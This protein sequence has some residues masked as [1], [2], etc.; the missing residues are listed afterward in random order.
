VVGEGLQGI[1]DTHLDEIVQ[2]GFRQILVRGL[3]LAGKQLRR[4]ERPCAAV[5]AEAGCEK[6]R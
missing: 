1:A 6:D 2:A 4:D 5:V 3:C